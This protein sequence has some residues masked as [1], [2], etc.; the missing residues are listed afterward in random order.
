MRVLRSVVLI[1]LLDVFD[2][3]HD[4]SSRSTVAPQLVGDDHARDI[5]TNPLT[6]CE[7]LGSRFAL[8]RAA[9]RKEV[10][11]SGPQSELMSTHPKLFRKS[12]AELNGLLLNLHG[13]QI[14]SLSDNPIFLLMSCVIARYQ[15]TSET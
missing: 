5:P 2:A 3:R 9:L 12:L 6:A 8:A 4:F 1:F 14:V 10:R 7:R 15:T 11:N 13:T